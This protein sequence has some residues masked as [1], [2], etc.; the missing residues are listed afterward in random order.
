YNAIYG[1]FAVVP[2]F[3]VWLYISWLIVIFGGEIT[4]RL[5]DFFLSGLRFSTILT[6]ISWAE[7]KALS[8][9]IMDHIVETYE[10]PD[11]PKATGILTLAK[12]LRKPLPHLGRAINCLQSAGLVTRVASPETDEF[13]P[14]FLPSRAPE[15]LS[16]E[17]VCHELEKL[18][19][20]S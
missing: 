19:Q 1:S 15:R 2:L 9:L 7:L 3:M 20:P 14:C 11:Q 18:V 13:G 5:A 16:P 10:S 6:P 17:V 8:I 4:R 12:I